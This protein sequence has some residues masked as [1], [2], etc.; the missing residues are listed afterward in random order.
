MALKQ[1]INE[2]PGPQEVCRAHGW[3]I[4][5]GSCAEGSGR[6]SGNSPSRRRASGGFRMLRSSLRG[7]PHQSGASWRSDRHKVIQSADYL[8]ER[9][10]EHLGAILRERKSPWAAWDTGGAPPPLAHRSRL[11]ETL[12]LPTA[13]AGG[14]SVSC[15]QSTLKYITLFGWFVY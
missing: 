11:P 14:G 7:K 6:L 8:P 2:F 3:R 13:L 9:H 5:E 15:F 10:W 1:V 4:W 12:V